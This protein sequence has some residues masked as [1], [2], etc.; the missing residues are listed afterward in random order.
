MQV[1]PPQPV[2]PPLHTRGVRA[3]RR[4]VAGTFVCTMPSRAPIHR[5][6][7]TGAKTLAPPSAAHAPDGAEQ[8]TAYGRGRGGRPW[9]RKRDAVMARD[10]RLCRCEECAKTGRLRIADEVDHIIPLSQGGT[11]DLDNLQAINRDCH[12]A[13]TA[14]E[15][16]LG[17]ER[18]SV[19]PGWLPDAGDHRLIV[20]CGPPAAGK[21]TYVSDR[22]G[23]GDLV[24]DL[25][26]MSEEIVGKPLWQT[27]EAERNGLIRIRN[28]R[29]ADFLRGKTG[30]SV[31]W[32]IVTAGSFRQRK[33]WQDK[34]HELVVLDTPAV[35]C[36]WRL[37]QRAHLP[38]GILRQLE[39]AVDNWR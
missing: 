13:K 12:R 21:T 26:R 17:A 25:D 9:R 14:R 32:L 37:R 16:F 19:L 2:S 4:E 5:P 28:A 20:V 15:S 3:S 1:L 10:K 30:H 27:G 8:A 7:R 6:K 34:G 24:L 29:A 35:Q 11:D 31:C 38:D 39:R 33:F 23:P 22:A 18:A 36:K